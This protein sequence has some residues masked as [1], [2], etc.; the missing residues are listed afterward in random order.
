MFIKVYII[1]YL[2]KS[3]RFST[4]MYTHYKGVN[5]CSCAMLPW[6]KVVS[7]FLHQKWLGLAVMG[8]YHSELLM[9]F[10]LAFLMK[11]ICLVLSY[12]LIPLSY[13]I[14]N[15][16]SSRWPQI[17]NSFALFLRGINAKKYCTIGGIIQCEQNKPL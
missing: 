2:F 9:L 15:F 14:V 6:E 1:L 3:I 7:I 17:Q 10:N 13:Q 12:I 5:W 16:K 4:R 11:C 8:K